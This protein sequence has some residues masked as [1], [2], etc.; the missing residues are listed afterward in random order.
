MQEMHDLAGGKLH[1]YKRENSDYWQCSSYLAGRNHRATTKQ[2]DL[3]RAKEFA[4]EWYLG[5]RVKHRSGELRGGRSFTDAAKKF[6]VEYAALTAGERNPEY[7]K[8]HS[9]RL[10]VHLTPFFG[11]TA[12]SEITPQLVQ[13]YRVQQNDLSQAPEDRRDVTAGPQHDSPGDRHAAARP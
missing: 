7:V 3:N 8:G 13:D 1:V 5:L 2:T 9:D 12:V 6:E 11:S 4:E 10:R